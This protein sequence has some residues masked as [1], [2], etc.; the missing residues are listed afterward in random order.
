MATTQETNV[1][2]DWTGQITLPEELRAPVYKAAAAEDRKCT[3]W[4]ARVLKKELKK[5]GFMSEQPE[6]AAAGQGG[7]K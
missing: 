7:G 5:R 6:A 1:V 2:G 3:N 4:V